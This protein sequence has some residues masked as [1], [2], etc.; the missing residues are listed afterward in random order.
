VLAVELR[1]GSVSQINSS[2]PA[3]AAGFIEDR[4][5]RNPR[6]QFR[7]LSTTS[8]RHITPSMT[9]PHRYLDEPYLLM[10]R[11]SLVVFIVVDVL[12]IPSM[13][14]GVNAHATRREASVL[15]WPPS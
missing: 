3:T 9:F 1:A 4:S 6:E 15:T 10:F 13:V 14:S 12:L 8:L 7:I 5:P 11:V 2:F